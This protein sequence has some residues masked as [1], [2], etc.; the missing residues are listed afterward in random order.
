[1]SDLQYTCRPIS[2]GRGAG[3]ALLSTDALCFALCD[4]GS[5]RVLEKGHCLDGKSVAGKVLVMP[6]GKGSSVVQ[7]DGLYRLITRGTAPA[8]VVIQ[9]PEPVLVSTIIAMEVPLV[10]EVDPA[11][12]EAVDEGD[13]VTVDAVAGRIVLEKQSAPGEA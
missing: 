10:D 12:Y 2:E 6:T 4:P 1:M 8:A 7:A 9:T 11:F 5:G 13:L 3:E